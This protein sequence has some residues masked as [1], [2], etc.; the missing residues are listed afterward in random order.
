MVL[1]SIHIFYINYF[2]EFS[3]IAIFHLSS[4]KSFI[5]LLT[6]MEVLSIIYDSME[7]IEENS[8]FK[9]SN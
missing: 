9:S 2:K 5:Q 8:L 1:F 4:S 3:A 7:L 6:W